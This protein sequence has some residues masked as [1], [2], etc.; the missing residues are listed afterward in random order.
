MTI[1]LCNSYK[2]FRSVLSDLVDP[3]GAPVAN[4][5]AGTAFTLLLR[6]VEILRCEGTKIVDL[7]RKSRR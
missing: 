5:P 4:P 2:T 1:L 3:F 7:P 6:I